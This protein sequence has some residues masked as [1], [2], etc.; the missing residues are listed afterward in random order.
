MNFGGSLLRPVA[1]HK[2]GFGRWLFCLVHSSLNAHENHPDFLESAS[3]ENTKYTPSASLGPSVDKLDL[4]WVKAVL[5]TPSTSL[6]PGVNSWSSSGKKLFRGSHISHEVRGR[7]SHRRSEGVMVTGGPRE[8]QPQEVR[9]SYSHRR[10]REAIWWRQYK[11]ME[12]TARPK[13]VHRVHSRY[14]RIPYVS[15]SHSRFISPG[16][17]PLSSIQWQHRNLISQPKKFY[18]KSSWFNLVHLMS[19]WSDHIF[20]RYS[21][22]IKKPS[23]GT[24]HVNMQ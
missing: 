8:S 7:H 5:Y 20:Q 19:W 11:M 14:T 2:Q 21:K 10:S 9:G 1:G 15:G 18:C 22:N 16:F 12:A 13:E 6:V 4:L 17:F 3:P 24:E 23:V